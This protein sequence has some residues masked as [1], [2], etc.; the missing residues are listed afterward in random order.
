MATRLGRK[1]TE[2]WKRRI[3]ESR[4]GKPVKNKYTDY[5]SDWI[6]KYQQ[7]VEC[8]DIAVEYGCSPTTVS[9][10]IR[11][12]NIKRHIVKQSVNYETFSNLYSDGI[13]APEIASKF[14]CSDYCVYR[15]LGLSGLE[16]RDNS[17]AR[18]KYSLDESFFDVINT[19]PKAYWLGFI[20]ADGCISSN[21]NRLIIDL[22]AKDSNT[23]YQFLSDLKSDISPNFYKGGM[24]K[25]R[26]AVRIS[27]NNK[28]LINTLKLHGITPRK[29]LT[30]NFC[31][32][33][34]G[35][36]RNGYIRGYFDGD[37]SL[38]FDKAKKPYFA[39]VGT[40]M[41]LKSVQDT[42][43][44]ELGLNRT[45]IRS[46][47]KINELRYIGKNNVLKV[48]DWLYQ[49]GRPWMQR[50]KDRFDSIG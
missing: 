35:S 44:D 34:P 13:S 19:I 31:E 49:G 20:S 1:H 9:R 12:R 38:Y 21:A 4:K 7:G 47:G 42:M 11:T 46:K 27:I 10:V 15:A 40:T 14:G 24:G 39:L 28:N 16:R 50:K 45:K 22:S 23:I 17:H 43:V 33:V 8:R 36:L 18:R 30:L 5:Y 41:F 32:N 26:N 48:R 2:E 3:S 6:N 29:S 37:G 25:T